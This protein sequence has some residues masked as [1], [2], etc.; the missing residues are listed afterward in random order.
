MNGDNILY[1]TTGHLKRFTYRT[2]ADINA[3]IN[4][5]GVETCF[6]VLIEG[7]VDRTFSKTYTLRAAKFEVDT[8]KAARGLAG[9]VLN[10]KTG[11]IVYT[12]GE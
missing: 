5:M 11:E 3:H 6:T 2:D 1:N 10:A 8:W 9:L 4:A 7:V 12:V